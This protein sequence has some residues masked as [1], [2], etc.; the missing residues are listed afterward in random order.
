[1][2]EVYGGG[3][4][5]AVT[6]DIEIWLLGALDTSLASNVSNLF[7]ID[8]QIFSSPVNHI[9]KKFPVSEFTCYQPGECNSR[10]KI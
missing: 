4:V 5:H 10:R 2:N 3:N 9:F 8:L 7:E 6:V 1:M